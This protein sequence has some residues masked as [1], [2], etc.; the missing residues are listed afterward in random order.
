MTRTKKRYDWGPMG[1]GSAFKGRLQVYQTV[2]RWVMFRTC[3]HCLP[4]TDR[5]THSVLRQVSRIPQQ[6]TS[7][8]QPSHP[9][10]PREHQSTTPSTSISPKINIHQT[11]IK[12]PSR[13]P[14]TFIGPSNKAK[15]RKSCFVTLSHAI[16]TS[17]YCTHL[18]ETFPVKHASNIHRAHRNMIEPASVFIHQ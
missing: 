15:Y 12:H 13:H 6:S 1:L 8:N 11:F 9:S 17:I 16:T 7:T 14:S 5:N 3:S 4:Q 10:Q 2:V 18:Q